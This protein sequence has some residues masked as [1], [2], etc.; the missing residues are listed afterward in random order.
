MISTRSRTARLFT[1]ILT[2][3]ILVSLPVLTQ[4]KQI[5]ILH[6][7]DMHASFLP[8]EA[9]W[10][11]TT[12]K[13]L[14]GG[15]NELAF[16]IDSVRKTKSATLLLD[17]GD[18]MT[19]NPITDR[20]Y[21]GAEGGALVEMLNLMGYEGWEPG[22]HDFDISYANFLQLAS[23]AKFPV[24]TANLVDE[25]SGL[26][27]TRKEYVIVE[28]NGL[29]IGVFGVM[30][31]EYY[32]LVSVNSAK[33]VKLLPYLAEAKRMIDFL[34]PQT[35]LVIALTH[36]GVDDDSVL[37]AN[38]KG[39][40]VIIGGHSHTRLKK[41]K[42]VNGVII[43]Q[44]GSNAENLGVL[45][46]TIENKTVTRWDGNLNQLWYH[47]DRRTVVT[48]LVDSFNTEIKREYSQVIGTWVAD[49]TSD[50]PEAGLGAFLAAAQRDAAHA[51][52]GFMNNGGVRKKLSP[53]PITKQDLFE[54]LPFRNLLMKFDLTG[55]QVQTM[56]LHY[57]NGRPGIIIAGL[58]CEWK[59]SA[60]GDVEILK[61]LINGKP[62]D[63]NATYTGAASD[64]LMGE[65]KR[66][67][68]IDAPQ[69]TYMNETVF[70]AVEKRVR[71][72][73]TV[74]AKAERPFKEIK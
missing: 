38:V 26:P 63:L 54:V 10:V 48:A 25:K 27:I 9:Y 56:V 12:P 43:A 72:M 35:D 74:E 70:N 46:L 58:S 1:F 61:L 19:G 49:P 24:F 32:S 23:I 47:S 15:F 65:A 2:T 14:V 57:L 68:G 40:D 51:D 13:P 53:G 20:V 5:T 33:G 67:L 36:T 55:K 22:N 73:K 42:Y 60:S 6:T 17:A 50:Q 29:K 3:L 52:L 37:A 4:P 21:K 39:L 28:K 7:N 34:R 11:R 16:T 41:P 30:S 44:A 69:L 64:Y 8:H 66:Y 62:V 31:Q 45:D 71:E 59:K 18:L